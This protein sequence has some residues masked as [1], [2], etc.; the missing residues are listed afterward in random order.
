MFQQFNLCQHCQHFLNHSA[1]DLFDE[2]LYSSWPKPNTFQ[3]PSPVY[4]C[5]ISSSIK[6]SILHV[7]VWTQTKLSLG[8]VPW[9][10]RHTPLAGVAFLMATPRCFIGCLMFHMQ[11]NQMILMGFPGG[12]DG[13][14]SA[15]N[16]G[17][18]G[19]IPGSGRSLGEGKAIHISFGD[20]L[21]YV[22]NPLFPSNCLFLAWQ[23]NCS[24]QKLLTITLYTKAKRI[25]L[26]IVCYSSTHS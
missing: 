12:L 26:P 5:F 25:Y 2:N 19:L 15:C 18:L 20:M 4:S 17:D 1:R 13:K 6:L 14:E 11:N 16:V 3:S 22:S 23:R 21:S 8:L 7:R 9:G 24:A 10:R